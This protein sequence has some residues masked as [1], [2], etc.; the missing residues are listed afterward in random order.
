MIFGKS[1]K[2]LSSKTMR[3]F[4]NRPACR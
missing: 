1:N 3:V 4:G 2:N